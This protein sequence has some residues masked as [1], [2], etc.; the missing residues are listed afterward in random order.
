VARSPGRQLRMSDLAA[1]TGMSTSGITR[2]V[3]RLERDGLLARKASP[4]DRRS[5]LAVLTGGGAER[6]DTLLPDL[7]DTIQRCLVEPLDQERYAAFESTLRTIRD[8]INP[9]ATAGAAG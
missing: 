9:G 1:Q 6:L 7:L 5:S 2:V 4:S 3:D 8:T